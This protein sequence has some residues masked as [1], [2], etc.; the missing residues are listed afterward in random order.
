MRSSTII[1]AFLGGMA[2]ASAAQAAS[3][4]CTTADKSTWL[5]PAQIKA[6]LEQHGFGSIGQIK[7]NAGNCYVVQ[8]TDNTGAK[9]TLYLDP[10]DGALMALE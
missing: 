9:K 6:M 10:T 7:A 2:I 4:Q 1:L 3:L 5:P 8:A